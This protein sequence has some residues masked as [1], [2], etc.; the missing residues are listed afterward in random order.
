MFDRVSNIP[1]ETSLKNP[2][3]AQ[4]F[5]HYVKSVQI[6]S[7]FWSVFGHF[8]RSV[9]VGSDYPYI[10]SLLNFMRTVAFLF[11]NTIN[12]RS[13]KA[14]PKIHCYVLLLAPYSFHFI[15]PCP[16]RC[17]VTTNMF[18]RLRKIDWFEKN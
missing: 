10:T 8:S 14:V 17:M 6:R 3:I 16:P 4:D 11:L 2:H 7:F 13:M 18:L 12:S 9:L 1:L 5:F 15:C